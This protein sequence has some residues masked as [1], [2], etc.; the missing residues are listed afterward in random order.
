M[1]VFEQHYTVGGSTHVYKTKDYDFDVGLHY[2]GGKLDSWCSPFR[3]LYDWLSDGKLEWCR[4]ADIYD[5]AYNE[6]T[7]ERLEF[8][9]SPRANRTMILQQFP[10]L[11]PK[12]L[13]W[14][15]TMCRRARLVAYI[16]FAAKVLS[17]LA[18]KIIWSIG[19]GSLYEKCCLG[20]TLDVMR[21]CGLP[22]DVIGAITYSY[23]DYGTPP[24]K[25]PFFIQAF[26]ENHYDGGGFF[27]K[28][29]SSSFAK[30]FVAAIQRCGG[31]VFAG[32]PVDKILTSKTMFGESCK[33]TGV[34]VKGVEIRARKCVISDAGFTKTFDVQGDCMPLV[35]LVSG[36]TQLSLVH[37]KEETPSFTPSPA[38]FYLF[39]GLNGSDADL[40]LVGQ[41]IWH[42]QDWNHSSK[43]EELNSSATIEEALSSPPPMVFLSNESAKDPDF[44]IRRPGKST[45]TIIAWTNPHWFEAFKA[46]SHG[47]RGEQ[48]ERI[49]IKMTA[50]LLDVLY[51]HFP[52]TK[53]KVSFAELGTPL[54]AQKYLGRSTGEIYNLDH[55]LSR[56][57]DVKAQLA[58]H[59]Q[60][61]IQDLF[62]TGQDVL[63]VSVEGATL[64]GCFTTCRVSTMALILAVPVAFACL[65]VAS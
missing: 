39:V 16:A 53:G 1:V 60:T 8:T 55:T 17:P 56:F 40:G 18:T 48:Y 49:K 59:P 34:S 31:K 10:S 64:S 7:R 37:R 51:H 6:T 61:T 63:A 2:V 33:A 21:S 50:T 24:S 22:D 20:T 65:W 25:S 54:S 4:I 32:A 62:L 57:K 41:N 47:N 45:V 26:M 9:G 11:D 23:G 58:L 15:L 3:L 19:F 27:P 46:T 52:L 14:Y 28:G 38:F 42:A 13:D 5:V 44:G 43:L 12:A 29:G 36:A 30:T 35:D